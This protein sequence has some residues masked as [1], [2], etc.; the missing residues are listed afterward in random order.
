MSTLDD[1]IAH[2]TAKSRAGSLTFS[3]PAIFR[4]TSLGPAA[5]AA[6]APPACCAGTS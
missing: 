2:I 1:R 4:K 6:G 3:P 5:Q